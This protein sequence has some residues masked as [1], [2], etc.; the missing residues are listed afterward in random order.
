MRPVDLSE[1]FCGFE[2]D[3]LPVVGA[4][5]ALQL[6][7]SLAADADFVTNNRY[8][9]GGRGLPAAEVGDVA[10]AIGSC[11]NC[12]LCPSLQRSAL[13]LAAVLVSARPC[14]CLR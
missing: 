9:Y 13:R 1:G 7:L 4:T 14:L 12:R 8:V 5:A 6:L 2:S 10:E 11:L 3:A